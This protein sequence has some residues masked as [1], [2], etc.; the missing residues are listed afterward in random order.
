[1][2]LTLIRFSQEKHERH[3]W[4]SWYRKS[5]KKV[6]YVFWKYKNTKIKY[7]IYT[8]YIRFFSKGI[9]IQNSIWNT[10]HPWPSANSIPHRLIFI[11][12]KFNMAY[13]L[14]KFYY[15]ASFHIVHFWH[16]NAGSTPQ[17]WCKSCISITSVKIL[18][19]PGLKQGLKQWSSN[20]AR[21]IHFPAEFSSS[22]EHANQRLQ[23]H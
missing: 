7:I 16:R 13:Y 3:V 14:I 10:A 19:Y 6:L 22:P 4:T 9:K 5:K 2:I 8:K 17:R 15:K 18:L 20:L 12:V 11:S 21:E 1:M 23:D